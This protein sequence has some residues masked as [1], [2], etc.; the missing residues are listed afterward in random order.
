MPPLF[1]L[2]RRRRLGNSHAIERP[3]H[4]DQRNDE[5][6]R[7]NPHF[8]RLILH[9]HRDLGREKPKQRREFDHRVQRNRRRVFERITDGVAHHRGCV[10]RRSFLPHIHFNDLLGV[11]K[12]LDVMGNYPDES[13]FINVRVI[14]KGEDIFIIRNISAIGQLFARAKYYNKGEVKR[15]TWNGAMFMESW[16]SQEISGYLADFQYQE[17]KQDQA[18]ELIVAVNLPK[19]SILS[20]DSSSTLMVSP[21]PAGQ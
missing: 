8:H 3:P 18:K 7:P 13:A 11:V 4:E 21:L 10:Q 17:R 12:Y 16:R 9:R 6:H 2:G 20:T 19:E 14:A 15:L 5:E 1:A